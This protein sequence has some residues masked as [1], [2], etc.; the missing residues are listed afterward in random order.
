MKAKQKIKGRQRTHFPTVFSKIY[1]KL[2]YKKLYS[3]LSTHE[4]LYCLQFG[5]QENHSIDHALIS[6]TETIRSTLDDK[7]FGCGVFDTVNHNILISKLE[8]YGVR[9]CAL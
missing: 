6:M 7:K 3:F 8:H 4:I 1:E 9:G 5:F 2:M